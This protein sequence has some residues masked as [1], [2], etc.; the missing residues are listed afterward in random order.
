MRSPCDRRSRLL[1]LGVIMLVL[2]AVVRPPLLAQPTAEPALGVAFDGDEVVVEGL[3]PGSRLAWLSL[4]SEPHRYHVR[5][6]RREGIETA[7]ATGAARIQLEVEVPP[8]SVWGFVDLASGK[9]LWAAPETFLLEET[10]AGPDQ[11]RPDD[12]GQLSR[13]RARAVGLELMAARPAGGPV[14]HAGSG[15]W[16]LTVFDGS[17]WDRDEAS[18]GGVE[19]ATDTGSPIADSPSPPEQLLPGDVILG[20]DPNTYQVFTLR[21]P[22]GQP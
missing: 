2:F 16:A 14:P 4:A 7:D 17:P 15:A 18:D 11:V 22:G 12:R 8:R 13:L 10:E 3:A 5:D 20:I 21:I 6:V 19:I 9:S 1:L